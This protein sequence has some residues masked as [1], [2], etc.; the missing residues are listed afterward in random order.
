MGHRSVLGGIA[1]EG[2]EPAGSGSGGHIIQDEGVDLPTEARLN[3]IGADVVATDDPGNGR[4]NVTITGVTGATGPP[5][6]DG[7]DGADGVSVGAPIFVVFD[8][9][10]GNWSVPAGVSGGWLTMQA[11]GAGGNTSTGGTAAGGGGA[12]EECVGIPIDVPDGGTV[13]WTVSD[14]GASDTSAGSCTFGDYVV[15][16]GL[17][18]VSTGVG[19]VGGGV[20]GGAGGGNVNPGGGGRMGLASHALFWC[21][22]GGGGGGNGATADGG[23]GGGAGGRIG[24]GAGGTVASSKGGGGGGAATRHGQGGA[25]GNGDQAGSAAS[26]T[27]YGAGGGGGGMGTKAGG[28]GGPGRIWF[29]Y[30]QP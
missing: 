9:G 26:A 30:L 12:G 27:A 5:G 10:S 25:G 8:V 29:A 3:F 28:K 7:A 20:N 14:G 21:G 19:G 17:H 6:A 15:L 22:S 16:G 11:P 13:A 2:P 24:G 18:G 4:T 23:Q 1:K